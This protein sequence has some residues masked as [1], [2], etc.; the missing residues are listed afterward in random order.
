MELLLPNEKNS[1]EI[2]FNTNFRDRFLGL[3]KSA[4]E[5]NIW[6]REGK[7]A[8]NEKFSKLINRNI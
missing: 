1:K 7:S 8:E 2:T 5:V 6:N 4:V 3:R